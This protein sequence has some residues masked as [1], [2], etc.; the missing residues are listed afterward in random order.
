MVPIPEVMQDS[1]RKVEEEMALM[2]R[3]PISSHSR[4]DGSDAI[5]RPGSHEVAHKVG[6]E[7]G[8][9]DHCSQTG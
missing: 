6:V 1:R 8:H 2:G 4:R 9:S 5:T 7:G 3:C